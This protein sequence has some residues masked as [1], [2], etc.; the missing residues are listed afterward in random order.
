MP[1]FPNNQ[2]VIIDC[3]EKGDYTRL[4]R[5]CR[6]PIDYMGIDWNEAYTQI[7]RDGIAEVFDLNLPKSIDK[8]EVMH[9]LSCDKEWL[10]G[11]D[12]IVVY[13]NGKPHTLIHF[14]I[15]ED[16]VISSLEFLPCH[17]L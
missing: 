17:P 6:G 3:I 8:L 2:K 9:L 10:L 5:C 1:D 13:S 4:V 15:N 14:D 12:V 16:G 11:H 7:F